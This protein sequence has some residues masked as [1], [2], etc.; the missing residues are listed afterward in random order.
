LAR[1]WA[2]AVPREERRTLNQAL[3]AFE[4][5]EDVP[6]LATVSHV[7]SA[8]VNRTPYVSPFLDKANVLVVQ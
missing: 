3:D 1:I 2:A 6:E 5:G 4:A 8:L 7:L